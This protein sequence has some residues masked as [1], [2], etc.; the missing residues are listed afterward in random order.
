M[1]EPISIKVLTSPPL[2]SV[3]AELKPQFERATHHALVVEVGPISELKQRIDR[4]EAFDAAILTPALIDSFVQNGRIAASSRVAIAR[5]GL[6]AVARVGTPKP[7]VSSADAF[8]STL[9]NAKSILFA[10]RSAVREHIEHT[11]EQLGI[12][13][14]VRPKS[15]MLP[16]GGF[17]A[18]AVADGAA[19]LGLTT[20]PT[21]LETA[22][23]EFAGPFP[24]ALQFYVSLSAGIST[25]STRQNS[26]KALLRY[27]A[28]PGVIE[29]M[30]VKGLDC[31][32]HHTP[33]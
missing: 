16:A 19:D 31:V 29:M 28:A 13:R 6:G 15:Q 7:D 32:S 12:A 5:T 30:R 4:G 23:V 24:A 17:I 27:F 9:L 18:K 1:H 33:S 11:F 14:Q 21:I 26:A 2:R 8:R 3:L 25:A 20:I 10:S 22:G